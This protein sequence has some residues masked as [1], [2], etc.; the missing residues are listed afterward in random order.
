MTWP[1]PFYVLLADRER[2][3]LDIAEEVAR[4]RRAR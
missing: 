4:E 3:G 2:Y 1:G